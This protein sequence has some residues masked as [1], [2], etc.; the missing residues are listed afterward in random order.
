MKDDMFHSGMWLF[1]ILFALC[2]FSVLSF[3]KFPLLSC[4]VQKGYRNSSLKMGANG[5]VDHMDEEQLSSWPWI[6]SV[7]DS[8][9]YCCIEIFLL[10]MY[11][12]L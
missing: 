2:I 9:G 7:L 4:Q 5:H 10:L 12:G 6:I 11:V 1:Y 8:K 3:C